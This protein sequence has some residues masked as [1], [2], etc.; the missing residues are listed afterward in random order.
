M[1]V[2]QKLFSSY[3]GCTEVS[4]PIH[5]FVM[6]CNSIHIHTEIVKMFSVPLT[7]R[8]DQ[9]FQ[10]QCANSRAFV[11]LRQAFLWAAAQTWKQCFHPESLD[12]SSLHSC[13]IPEF[14]F[15]FYVS[16]QKCCNLHFDKILYDAFSLYGN[17]T[18]SLEILLPA[19]DCLCDL[20]HNTPLF[21]EVGIQSEVCQC[22]H[23]FLCNCFQPPQYP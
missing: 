17:R 5:R 8:C 7:F 20:K 19:T 10:A 22:S 15:H 11:T 3:S 2:F 4:I 13:E 6:L 18:A 12:W 14:D 1:K 23:H 9:L 16:R 21:Q